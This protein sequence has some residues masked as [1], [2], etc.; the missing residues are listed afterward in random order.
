MADVI[1]NDSILL[2]DQS[3]TQLILSYENFIKLLWRVSIDYLP[4]E[5]TVSPRTRLLALLELM[6]A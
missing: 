4:V 2:P 1:K 3:Q 5:E 6:D